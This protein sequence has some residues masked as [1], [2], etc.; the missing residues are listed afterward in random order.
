MGINV[1]SIVGQ[2]I[3]PNR[4]GDVVR[5][6]QVQTIGDNPETVEWWN[7]T[8]EDTAP[9]NGDYVIIRDMGAGFKIGVL[10]RDTI[11]PLVNAGERKIYSRNSAGVVQAFLHL[12]DDGSVNLH[13]PGGF[14]VTG[15]QTNTGSLTVSGII[16]SA[17][18][19][20]AN[21]LTTAIT[22]L[23]HLHID[24]I[25]GTGSPPQNASATPPIP[26][27]THSHPQANDSNDDTEADVGPPK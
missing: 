20:I 8:G 7:I 23:T 27:G 22:L 1:G 18:D 6:L 13:A 21:W 4:A 19:I 9:V 14:N 5:F 12:K 25:G 24:S 3:G 15:D 2:S 16:K 10:V 26:F 11:D 17:V